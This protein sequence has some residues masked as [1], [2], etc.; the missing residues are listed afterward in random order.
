MICQPHAVLIF[1][2]FFFFFPALQD[3]QGTQMETSAFPFYSQALILKL[4]LHVPRVAVISV[5][6]T[7][8]M[9]YKG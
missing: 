7:A 9:L 6:M 3:V 2:F 5:Q 8:E 1:F 4:S